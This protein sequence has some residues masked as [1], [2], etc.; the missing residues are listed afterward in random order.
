M[1]NRPDPTPIPGLD[2]KALRRD[3]KLMLPETLLVDQQEWAELLDFSGQTA[4]HNV[5][6]K[7]ILAATPHDGPHWRTLRPEERTALALFML[8]D[9]PRPAFLPAVPLTSPPPTPAP[10]EDPTEP[11]R[12]VQPSGRFAVPAGPG[13]TPDTR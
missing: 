2:A 4:R 5:I 8:G 13:F 3:M 10:V 6:R 9:G 7:M 11:G 1:P 12:Y